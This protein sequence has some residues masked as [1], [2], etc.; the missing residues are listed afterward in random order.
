MV[1]VD[2]HMRRSGRMI[3]H[4]GP[5][6]YGLAPTLT[7]LRVQAYDNRPS[8]RCRSVFV[9]ATDDKTSNGGGGGLYA[10]A[11]AGVCTQGAPIT[12]DDNSFDSDAQE[13]DALITTGSTLG[14][15]IVRLPLQLQDVCPQLHP[16]RSLASSCARF[17]MVD[18]AP[19]HSKWC[20]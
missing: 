15:I 20:F 12:I 13:G 5:Q 6:G 7:E 2:V 19:V 1:Q 8:T 14:T 18:C 11:A 9:S 17:C 10:N 3:P 16:S 4:T